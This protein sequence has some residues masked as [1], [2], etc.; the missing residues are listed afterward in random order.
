MKKR[1]LALLLAVCIAASMLVLPVSAAGNNPAVQA[2]VTLGGLTA[3]QTD[4]A[5]LDA[6]LNRGQLA[7]LL[8]AFS[9]YRESAASQG[10]TGKLF[11]DVTADNCWAPYIRIA[12][13]QGWLSGYTD[14]SFRPDNGVTLEEACTAVLKLLGYDVT[15][16][17]GTFPAAQL[18][19]AS[20]LGLRANLSRKQGETMTLADG[21]V[22]LYNALTAATSEG[23]VYGTSLGFTVTDGQLD[24]SSILLRSLE[25]PFVAGSGESLPFV[26]AT[27]YRNDSQTDSAQLDPYDVYYYNQSAK[28]VWIYSRRAAGRIT[29]VS[30]S[31]SAPTSVTVAGV[32]YTLAS[33]AAASQLSSL[34]GGGV[35]QV[36]TLLLGMN[37]EAVA[38]LT[39]EQADEV[40][41]GVVQSASRSLIEENGADV[42]QTVTVACTD[43]VT[44]AVNVDKSLNYPAGWLVEITVDENGE[45][46]TA[47]CEKSVSGTFNAEGTALGEYPL[48][49]DVQILDTT[50]EGVA[51]TVRPSR[52][53]GVTLSASDV[54]YYTTNAAGEIDRLILDDVT[55]DLWT[56]GVLDDVRNL[57]THLTSSGSAG[58]T[59]SGSN[60]SSGSSNS[61][62]SSSTGSSGSTSAVGTIVSDVGGIVLPSTSEMLWGI[63][64]GSIGSAVW[65]SVTSSTSS[66]ASYLLKLGENNTTGLLSKTLNYF[67]TGANYV[68]YVNGTQTTYQTSVKYPV[69][70]G[71]IAV[72]KTASGSVKTMRQ[73]LP[74]VVDQLGAASVR[75]GNTRYETADAMQVYLWYKG[76]YYATTLS[77]INT[78]DYNLIGWYDNNGSAA[79]KK[80]RVLIAV[81]KDG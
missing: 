28:T 61:S 58:S 19:K 7:K 27:V 24:T 46:V 14:G 12:V 49:D 79:G 33:S 52:L 6:A 3:D 23:G 73:L 41:Y 18:N 53:S 20:S 40:F 42:Q 74:V 2:A 17:S 26:P 81:K 80:I 21:A 72:G 67:G 9:T 63:L 71:G 8:T 11:S 47:L 31:A 75:S 13:Q 55:G 65:E 30:P 37:D 25:G 45:N 22:L 54:K 57:V 34:N 69:L 10:T 77:Q 62:G 56:Y 66:L 15:T 60:A 51:G 16:L 32:S 64:D 4:E 35:G 50:T 68:C 70:A 5:S 36:V 38:V 59:G 39:G 44:R 48:A 76:A 29:A 43:G 78:E 1:F